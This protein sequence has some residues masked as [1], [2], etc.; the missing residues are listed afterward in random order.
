MTTRFTGLKTA[1]ASA[2]LLALGACGGGSD[3]APTT[4]AL[5]TTVID[6]AIGNALVC[7][8]KNTNNSCDADETQGRTDADGKVTLAVPNA[9]AGRCPLVAMVGTDAVDK[10]HGSVTIA[11]VMSAP[12]DHATVVS[13]LTTLV[14]QTIASSGTGSADA[15]RVVQE[16]TGIQGSLYED[17]TTAPA[18]TDGS[19]APATLARM[20]V[21]TM[22]QQAA[23]LAPALGTT[24]IDG[25]TITQADLDKIVQMKLLE[26]LPSIVGAA[27]DP[28]VRA[29]ASP[30]DA[31]AAIAAAVTALVASEGLTAAGAVTVVAVNNQAPA[32]A[33]AASA[34]AS[35]QLMSLNYTSGTSYALRVL[36]STEAQSAPDAD[37][38]VRY[39]DRRQ[40]MVAG[41]LATWSSGSDP[42]RNADLNWNGSA[43]T[44]CPVNFESKSSV[45]DSLGANTYSY[46]DQRETGRSVRVSFEVGGK[47]MAE[48]Y[49]QIRAA[50]YS[51]LEITD[52]AALGSAV[53]PAGSSVFYTT[54]TPVSEA[55]SYYPSGTDNPP[56]LGNTVMQYSAE[57]A[58][59]G[60]ATAQPP[61]P[62]AGRPTPRRTAC[63]SRPSKR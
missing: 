28:A 36:T 27:A 47:S 2:T 20:V 56:G 23:A 3:D 53:F 17:Y 60:D 49:A 29:A 11:Y 16:A 18:P 34:A 33:A 10:D 40:R 57:V 42:W 4:T 37:N 14:Q 15:A 25:A 63:R 41:Q 62:A 26:L 9:D 6:G 7:I 19:L 50:G 46:C 59:G 38:K 48:V 54:N 30:A 52:T 35:M 32:P 5:T 22:Q 44:S 39:V 1:L 55:I 31:E 51:N 8:D 21:V 61:A 43:W 45:R 13:P 58:A 24:A 12:A